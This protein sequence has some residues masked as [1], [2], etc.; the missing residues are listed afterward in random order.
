MTHVDNEGWTALMWAAQFAHLDAMRVLLDHPSDVLP[1][2]MMHAS[3]DGHATLSLAAH[4]GQ[5]GA[6]RLLLDHPSADPARMMAFHGVSGRS[7]LVSAA[8]FAAR[9]P[10]ASAPPPSCDP[11]LLLLRGAAMQPGLRDAQEAH[12]SK[13]MEALM[14]G[15]QLGALFDDDQ[16][17]G[18]RDEVVCLLLEFGA[19][20]V[21]ARCNSP[22]MLRIVRECMA[23]ARVSQLLNE[24]VRATLGRDDEYIQ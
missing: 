16:A 18:P 12:M 21:P 9:S 10:A 1:A 19:R 7:A 3:S 13:V 11:L 22:F 20:M 5:I 6:M 23:L 15:P 24:A 2:M 8:Q 4:N 14:E 17:D